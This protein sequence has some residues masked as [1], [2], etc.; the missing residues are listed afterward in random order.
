MRKFLLNIIHFLI[1]PF[2]IWGII[3]AFL[4]PTFF[5]HR[6]FEALSFKT[7]V[8]RKTDWYP[9]IHSKM[10]ATGDLCFNT[11]NSVF[12]S[13]EWI[14]DKFG[15]RNE[16]F[17]DKPDV[18]FLGDSFIM[19][20]SLSQNEL[21]SNQ[22]KIKSND[23][24]KVYNMAPSSFSIF[25][26]YLK[27]KNIK[28]PKL[29]IFSIVERNIP[30][31]IIYYN[32]TREMKYKKLIDDL[33]SIGNIN[34]YIDKAFKQ[35]SLQWIKA[36]INRSR[37]FGMQATGN[38]NMFFLNGITQ[39]PSESNLNSTVKIILSYKK[40]CDSND[41]RFIFMPMPDKESVYYELVPFK[42]QPNYLFKLDSLLNIVGV[43]TINTLK[44]YNNYRKSSS[45][46][47]YHLDDTHWN[48]NATDLISTAIISK[49]T[50]D[51]L[52]NVHTQ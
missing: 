44:I 33:F 2:F 14:T 39:N 30:E 3:E 4:P 41:I 31:P 1:I 48:S 19:G 29:I 5:T 9:N 12:K 32:V 10:M 43:S 8:P 6:H 51:S 47:L 21:I 24:I 23:R 15:Y 11:N 34:V 35:L 18:L 25:D 38:S 52:L 13:E 42:Q 45:K 40:Y 20:S 50:N 27:V 22:V 28:K 17:V 26:R 36:R 16:E 49:I 7:N 46:L 37:G